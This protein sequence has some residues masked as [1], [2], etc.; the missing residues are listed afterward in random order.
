[1]K[2]V[3]SGIPRILWIGDNP[4]LPT[5]SAESSRKVCRLL[6]QAGCEVF[7]YGLYR[8]FPP[9]VW[10]GITLLPAI[11]YTGDPDAAAGIGGATGLAYTLDTVRPDL[12]ITCGQAAQFAPLAA[13]RE[14]GIFAADIPWWHWDTVGVPAGG[15]LPAEIANVTLR[16]SPH[17]VDALFQPLDD[18]TVARERIQAGDRFVVGSLARNVVRWHLGDLLAALPGALG[19][20]DDLQFLWVEDLHRRE[21]EPFR[22]VLA[23]QGD[24]RY[25]RAYWTDIAEDASALVFDLLNDHYNAMDAFL[26]FAPPGVTDLA[27]LEAAAAG[28]PVVYL[29]DPAWPEQLRAIKSD[30]ANHDRRA[31]GLAAATQ[32]GIQAVGALWRDWL[33]DVAVPAGRDAQVRVNWFCTLFGSGSVNHCSREMILALDR[34]GADVTVEQPFGRFENPALFPDGFEEDYARRNPEAYAALRRIAAKRPHDRDFTNV[35]FIVSRQEH[36]PYQLMRSLKAPVIEYTNNDNPGRLAPD[37]MRPFAEPGPDGALP[38]RKLWAV[39]EYIKA[40]YGAATSFPAEFARGVEIVYHGVDTDLFNPWVQPISL[41]TAG[42]FTFLNCSFPRVQHKGL[43]VLCQSFAL[44]FAGDPGVCL[45][46]KLPSRNKVVAPQEYDDVAKVL[47]AAR[48]VPEC[49]E[50]IVIEE[51]TPGRGDMAAYYAAGHAYVHPSRWEACSISLLECLAVGLPLIVTRWGGHTEWCPEDLAYYVDCKPLIHD[52]G[53]SAEPDPMSL[54]TQMRH[55]Y[56]HQAEAR[57]RGAR[58]SAHI[59]EHYTWDASARRMIELLGGAKRL[60]ATSPIA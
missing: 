44:E 1:M 31:A 58:A 38:A 13:L 30:S 50:I 59:R 57:D 56:Q 54:R 41:P 49:P 48:S 35:R 2:P 22:R 17:P 6:G 40:I 55:V 14:S 21:L 4:A 5:L 37:F 53:R 33:R 16:V 3:S 28:T 7:Y 18:R 19:A 10:E 9:T 12:V 45:V 46:L 24:V 25:H 60:S 29:A 43:D 20:V 47:D 52:F 36:S 34:V 8:Q 51:D 11:L 42:R 15:A 26:S 27:A 32:H 23:D 39:S